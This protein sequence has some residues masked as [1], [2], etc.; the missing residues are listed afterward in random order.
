[1]RIPKKYG[2][3]KID[4]CPFCGKIGV[5]KNKQ[6]IPVCI[7]HK[8]SKLEDLKCV[9]GEYLDIRQGKYGPY[10]NCMNCGNINFRKGLEMNQPKEKVKTEKKEITVTSD[11]LDSLY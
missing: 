6:G 8:D 3:S 2:Q 7:N 9:C 11:Q 1:M 5:T 4:N 10:F